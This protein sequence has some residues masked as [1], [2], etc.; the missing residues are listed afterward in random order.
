MKRIEELLGMPLVTVAEG[1]RI[2]TLKGLE[3]DVRNGR[4]AYLR[5]DG[6]ARISGVVPWSAIRAVGTDAITI[7][8]IGSVLDA[9]PHGDL[10]NLVTHV[11]DRP[12]VTESGTR[13]GNIT[14]YDLDEATGHIVGYRLPNGGLFGRLT[15]SEMRFRHEQ[16]VSFGRDAIVVSDRVCLP[17][18][19]K[20]AA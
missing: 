8:S 10:P 16:I 15:G 11:G 13:V 7:E 9:I 3:I 20:Q 18:E 19:T 6:E 2:G 14:G 17:E 1:R 12:V 4:A 5:F